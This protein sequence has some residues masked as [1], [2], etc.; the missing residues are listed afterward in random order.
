MVKSLFK[1]SAKTDITRFVP[2]CHCETHSVQ[3]N[4]VKLVRR[5]IIIKKG[6]SYSFPFYAIYGSRKVALF[7]NQSNVLPPVALI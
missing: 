7:S 4:I 6:K 1:I 2:I 3:T 5:K